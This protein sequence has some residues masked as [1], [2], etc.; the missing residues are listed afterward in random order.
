MAAKK[1]A[2]KPKVEPEKVFDCGIDKDDEKYLYYV[3]KRCNVVR[4]ERGKPKAGTEI[5]VRTGL[6]RE[7]G[8]M[9]YV[10]DAGDLV[11]EPDNSRDR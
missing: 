8:W 3:D 11:R 10:D 9:Y 5:L 6:K 2:S 4:M 7:K 1:K